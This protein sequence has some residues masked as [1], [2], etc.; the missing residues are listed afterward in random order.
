MAKYSGSED[1]IR[2]GPWADFRVVFGA[3]TRDHARSIFWDDLLLLIPSKLIR[4]VRESRLEIRTIHGVKAE[5]VGLDE[6]RRI[7]GTPLDRGYF[8]EVAEMKEGVFD[9][10]IRPAM[11]TRGRPGGGWFFGVPRIGH[12]KGGGKEFKKL[13]ELA[14]DGKH[15][16]F[17][18]HHWGP[19]DIL[20][21]AE[22]Q[23]AKDTLD[24]ITFEQEYMARRVS[25]SGRAYKPFDREIHA[26]ERLPYNPDAPLIFC[27]D[28]NVSPGVSVVMQEHAFRDRDRLRTDRPEV[29]DNVTAAIGEVHIRNDSSTPKV[30][31]A[32]AAT[33]KDH[34]GPVLCYGDPAGGARSTKVDMGGTDWTE[35]RDWLKPTFGNRISIRGPGTEQAQRP[36]INALNR[37]LKTV[38]GKVRFLIDPEA[39]PKL[40]ED[41]E[42]TTIQPG[43]DGE[44]WKPQGT[45]YTHM[46][47]AVGYYMVRAHPIG[48]S[49]TSSSELVF[50]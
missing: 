5:V 28:F 49:G 16:D 12:V 30:C 25:I 6:P 15:P 14:R 24:E 10:H 32:L 47:D 40:V 41:L 18:Y 26:R 39:C 34:R 4:F 23:S 1:I 13:S 44:L 17:A 8:D 9:R 46:T 33:W 7:E 3:P 22:L 35:I 45:P 50:S 2:G 36:R 42:E 20:D 43:T 38:S 19:E 48:G 21:P 37:R 29:D 27:F 31:R 11:S